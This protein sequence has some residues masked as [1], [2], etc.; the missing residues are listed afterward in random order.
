LRSGQVSA[1]AVV[2]LSDYDALNRIAGG[3]VQGIW[4]A[5]EILR[6][7]LVPGGFN[8]FS[9]ISALRSIPSIDLKRAESM[10]S[11]TVCASATCP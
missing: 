4:T 2:K 8:R 7:V 6:Q 5:P 10:P 1:G 3:P 9:R 11:C